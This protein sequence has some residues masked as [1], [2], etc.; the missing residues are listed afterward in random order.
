MF[1]YSRLRKKL[2]ENYLSIKNLSVNYS[3]TIFYKKIFEII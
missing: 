2:S 1:K 3:N